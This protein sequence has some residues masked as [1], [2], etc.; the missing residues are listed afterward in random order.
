MQTLVAIWLVRQPRLRWI[1]Y[2]LMPVLAG[3]DFVTWQGLPLFLA[4]AATTLSS[5]GR[6]QT[7]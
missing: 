6:M 2:A 1:Y 3:T 4:A 5:V 7:R